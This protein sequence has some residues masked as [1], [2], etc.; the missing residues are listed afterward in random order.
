MQAH[1]SGISTLGKGLLSDEYQSQVKA[2]FSQ[3]LNGKSNPSS[4]QSD[5]Y[6]SV[7][8]EHLFGGSEAPIRSGK[9]GM[10][11]ENATKCDFD[12]LTSGDRK[13]IASM[14]QYAEA[15]NIDVK[16]I[17]SFA[18]DLGDYRQHDN[19]QILGDCN[20]GT[21]DMQGHKVTYSFTEKD[22]ATIDSLLESNALASSGIDRGFISHI[23]TPGKG[24]LGH[25][26]SF[27]FLQ[28]MVEVTAG[29]EPT[30][31][32][33]EFR[34]FKPNTK[35]ERFVRTLSEEVFPFPE[36]D[37][38]CK[39]GHCEVT[40]VGKKNGV[41]LDSAMSATTPDFDL[42]ADLVESLFQRIID[43]QT[44]KKCGLSGLQ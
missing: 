4:S 16:Y 43:P 26:G 28:H 30:V 5:H 17:Q 12:F 22:Q 38:V 35:E 20:E 7:M 6:Y 19:G 27:Q 11:I 23:T 3:T 31:P 1:F 42:K 2:R 33:D 13:L 36:P 40:E 29:E 10:T 9:D 18:M 34:H 32:A 44:Q 14:Y 24:V 39:N 15:I 8:V 25:F 21:Y 37:V 41:K